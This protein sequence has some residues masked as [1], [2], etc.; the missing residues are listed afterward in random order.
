MW[1]EKK[2][3]IPNEIKSL[4]TKQQ[5]FKLRCCFTC[6]PR[7]NVL[8][9]SSTWGMKAQSLGVMLCYQV[10][11]QVKQGRG[12]FSTAVD[13]FVWDFF[14]VSFVCLFLNHAFPWHSPHSGSSGAEQQLVLGG[15][16]KVLDVA[17]TMGTQVWCSFHPK[18]CRLCMTVKGAPDNK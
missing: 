13:L 1:A 12:F 8:E 4:N 15:L 14:V 5:W 16:V 11:S 6:I 17:L 18:S 9:L 10:I 2:T 7:H 3:S